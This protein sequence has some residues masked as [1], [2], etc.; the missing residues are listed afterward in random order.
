MRSRKTVLMVLTVLFVFVTTLVPMSAGAAVTKDTIYVDAQPTADGVWSNTSGTIAI[1]TAGWAN[2]A[3]P[4]QTMVTDPYTGQNVMKVYTPQASGWSAVGTTGVGVFPQTETFTNKVTWYEFD[5][6]YD[7][8]IFP[9]YAHTNGNRGFGLFHVNADGTVGTI[10]VSSTDTTG[11]RVSATDWNHVTV[12]VDAID[13]FY[14]AY[15]KFYVWVNGTL[16]DQDNRHGGSAVDDTDPSIKAF[17]IGTAATEGTFYLD[18]INMYTSSTAVELS[19]YDPT[20]YADGAEIT[21]AEVKADKIIVPEGTT[22][23]GLNEIIKNDATSITYWDGTTQLESTSTDDAI[24]KTVYVSN[25]VAVNKYTVSLAKA[26]VYYVDANPTGDGTWSQENDA[27]LAIAYQ[28]FI[29]SL[30][31]NKFTHTKVK[32]D[33]TGADVMKLDFIP[34]TAGAINYIGAGNGA[35]SGMNFDNKVTWYEV[36]FRFEDVLSDVSVV[37]AAQ[38]VFSMNANGVIKVGHSGVSA[39]NNFTP[40]ADKWYHL[41]VAV[42]N[43]NKYSSDSRFYAWINGTQLTTGEE[44]ITGATMTRNASETSSGSHIVFGFGGSENGNTVYVDNIK[45]YTTTQSVEASGYD[46]T[47]YAD[48]ST[49]T[50]AS[51]DVYGDTICVNEE[52]TLADIDAAIEDTLYVTYWNGATK[53]EDLNVAAIGKTVMTSNGVAVKEYKIVSRAVEITG[54]NNETAQVTILN[55][56]G[57]SKTA[58]IAVATY[59]ANGLVDFVVT[60]A[61]VAINDAETDVTLTS[62]STSDATIARVF[63]WDSFETLKPACASYDVSLIS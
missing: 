30:D 62:V 44:A 38:T 11:C 51:V 22:V 56:T 19:G 50:S 63:V 32:D 10:T 4:T 57:E 6:R 40:V 18:N 34:G 37:G 13:M 47:D 16:I 35:I 1:G 45:F 9:L 17:Y 33:Y 12:A 23:A 61:P 48:G 53:L 60:A 3:N 20:D 7:G 29:S 2:A 14:G 5:F 24:G 54:W 26:E 25:G 36:S 59:G 52:V 49:I 21:S 31:G 55:T 39:V 28:S 46:P 43:I 15:P 42:D 58:V 27:S 41:V 8:T